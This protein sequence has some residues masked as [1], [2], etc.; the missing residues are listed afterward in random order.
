MY[1]TNFQYLNSSAYL[2]EGNFSKVNHFIKN[3]ANISNF[4]T[5]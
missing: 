2:Q 4:E 5:H 1:H 3:Y